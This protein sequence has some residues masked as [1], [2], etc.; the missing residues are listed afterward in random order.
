MGSEKFLKASLN[1]QE[2]VEQLF[3]DEE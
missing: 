3:S 1:L 2:R